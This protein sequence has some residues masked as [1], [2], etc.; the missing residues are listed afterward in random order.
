MHLLQE[1]KMNKDIDN[2]KV[3]PWDSKLASWIGLENLCKQRK[4][5]KPGSVNW[6]WIMEALLICHRKMHT[7]FITSR[8]I[9]SCFILFFC[10]HSCFKIQRISFNSAFPHVCP[11]N[12]V[13]VFG[14]IF[15]REEPSSF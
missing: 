1:M 9:P 13:L 8:C 10:I 7:A 4:A 3:L 6:D 12:I 2:M 5:K 15:S 14:V 11:R